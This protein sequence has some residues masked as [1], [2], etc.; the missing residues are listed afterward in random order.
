MGGIDYNRVREESDA[1][2]ENYADQYIGDYVRKL[3]QFVDSYVHDY[4][5]ASGHDRMVMS[6]RDDVQ[7]IRDICDVLAPNLLVSSNDLSRRTLDDQIGWK[8]VDVAIDEQ[9]YELPN[10]MSVVPLGGGEGPMGLSVAANAPRPFSIQFGIDDCDDD[11]TCG[12]QTTTAL[13]QV[14]DVI[15]GYYRL[16]WYGRPGYIDPA[17]GGTRRDSGEPASAVVVRGLE[18]GT[19]FSGTPTITAESDGWSRYSL[20][21]YEP[22]GEAL[23]LAI[24]NPA[25]NDE[26]GAQVE[27]AGIMLED[28][29]HLGFSADDPGMLGEFI[30]TDSDGRYRQNICEDTDGN[31]FRARAWRRNCVSL[32][33]SGFG[34]GCAPSASTTY[35]YWEAQFHIAQ[36]AI[37]RGMILNNAGFAHGNFNYR[38]DSFAVNFVGSAARVCADAS[39]P[40]TCYS[41]GFIPYT[42]EHLGPYEVRNYRG[43]TL[44]VPLYPGVVQSADGLA[45]ERYITNP[46]SSADQAL[47]DQYRRYELQGRPL[48]GSYVLRVWDGPGVN[49]D[50]IEDVQIVLDYRYW[51]RQR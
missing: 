36:E 22:G 7:N 8:I 10:A 48:T 25:S 24:V 17:M 23:E 15:G 21:F 41:S 45:A 2:Y 34:S 32:C 4:P 51:T 11:G 6:L 50:G 35:C 43:D 20:V 9:G 44:S 13:T 33:D 12:Y 5:T 49:F 47:L 38:I 42:L 30:A 46:I 3:R 37:D 1:Q 27:L 26:I 39:L 16:S 28:V 19:V 40:S 18:S 29:S 31:Q 14:V